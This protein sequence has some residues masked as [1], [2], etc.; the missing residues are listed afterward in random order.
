MY[1]Q[2]VSCIREMFLCLQYS[3]NFP[4][5]LS[6]SMKLNFTLCFT[7]YMCGNVASDERNERLC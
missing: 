1:T 6:I 4:V 7:N 3:V 5:F 2:F